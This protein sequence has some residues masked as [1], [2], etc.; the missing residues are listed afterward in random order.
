[1]CA[2]GW[3]KRKIAEIMFNYDPRVHKRTHYHPAPAWPTIVSADG[4]AD[5]D[6]YEKLQSQLLQQGEANSSRVAGSSV[7]VNCKLVHTPTP[8]TRTEIASTIQKVMAMLHPQVVTQEQIIRAAF[9]AQ[10]PSEHRNLIGTLSSAIHPERRTPS[11]K[12]SNTGKRLM[13][14][15]YDLGFGHPIDSL[16]ITGVVEMKAALATFD[17]LSSQSFFTSEG[18]HDLFDCDEVPL[19]SP[20][21]KPEPLGIDLFKLLDPKLPGESFRISWIA[22]GKRGRTTGEEI[23]QQARRIITGVASKRNLSCGVD[24]IDHESR[25]LVFTWNQPRL[26][27][28]ELAWYQPSVCDSSKYETVFDKSTKADDAFKR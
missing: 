25:W 14:A 17:G 28:L 7:A 15:R 9:V 18:Q 16:G 5:L 8:T 11:N 10:L 19:P 23:R 6:Q 1:M 4:A 12:Y 27:R 24:T 21:R 2:R 13:C 22:L 3:Q 26:V 20:P